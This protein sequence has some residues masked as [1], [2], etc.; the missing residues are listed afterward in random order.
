[1]LGASLVHRPNLQLKALAREETK[2]M[3]TPTD[4]APTDSLAKI[5]TALGLDASADEGAILT[6]INR[7]QAA[8]DP[9]RFV[10]IEAVRDLM[11]ERAMNRATASEE[12]ATA[13]VDAAMRDGYLTP[14]MRDWAVASCS[15]DPAS[16]DSFVQSATPAYAHLFATPKRSPLSGGNRQSAS[17][18]EEADVFRQL[19]LNG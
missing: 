5:A 14:G 3:D 10:P 15:A 18:A 16:F 19:G 13:R 4:T 12:V 6:A 17:N 1:M 9:A 11:T 7:T 8:P 2:P